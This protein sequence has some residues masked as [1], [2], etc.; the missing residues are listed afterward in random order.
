MVWSRVQYIV[1]RFVHVVLPREAY[2]LTWC[3][4]HRLDTG[5]HSKTVQGAVVTLGKSAGLAR[6]G[7]H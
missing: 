4:V 2:K 5:L 1:S 3:S 6:V 7:L